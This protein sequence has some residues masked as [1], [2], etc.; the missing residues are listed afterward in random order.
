[1]VEA[2]DIN[3]LK[4]IQ[5]QPGKEIGLATKMA[6]LIKDSNKAYRRYEAAV[7]VFGKGA[8]SNIFYHRYL[9][10][11]HGTPA[12]VTVSSLATALVNKVEKKAEE[13]VEETV[14]LIKRCKEDFPIERRVKMEGRFGVVSSHDG[15]EE[16][17]H[18]RF[19]DTN[20][21]EEVSIYSIKFA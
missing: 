16:I 12:P 2:K 4:D 9:E 7:M 11:T 8:V 18:V 13:V 20:S 1:M 3:R 19:E 6:K 17:I 5:A 21:T 10:L 14:R 15:D